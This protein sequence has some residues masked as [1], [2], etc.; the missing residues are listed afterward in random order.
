MNTRNGFLQQQK[1]HPT[2]NHIYTLSYPNNEQIC[3]GNM[4]KMIHV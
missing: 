2:T 3:P 4:I 1:I